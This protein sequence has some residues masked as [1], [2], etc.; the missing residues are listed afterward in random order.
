MERD[1][2]LSH[3]TMMFL[4]ER[5]FDMSDKYFVYVCKNT[6]KIAAVNPQEDIYRSFYDNESTDFVKVQIPYA[7]KLFMQELEAMG[8][9]TKLEVE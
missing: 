6:G 1:S 4:R 9:N 7:T 8:I 3:G 5:M 2:I